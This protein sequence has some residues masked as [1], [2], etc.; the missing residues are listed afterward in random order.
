MSSSTKAISSKFKILNSTS[1]R[2]HKE[3]L[4][5][6]KFM[7]HCKETKT[8]FNS[9]IICWQTDSKNNFSFL[10]KGSRKPRIQEDIVKIKYLELELGITIIPIWTPRSH[11]R[12]ILADLGSKFNQSSDECGIFRNGLRQIFSKFKL[13]PTID[14]FALE[15]NS[16]CKHFF[17]FIFN[18]KFF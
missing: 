9:S 13:N 17:L 16:I 12:L 7:K 6:L 1:L 8:K 18:L 4:A 2:Q 15:A 3:L 5:T 11:S 14:R 10:S